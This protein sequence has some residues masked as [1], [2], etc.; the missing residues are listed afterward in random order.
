M[1]SELAQQISRIRTQNLQ[2]AGPIRQGVPSLFLSPK[3]AAGIDIDQTYDAALNGLITLSQYDSR[4]SAFR[5]GILHPSSMSLQREL[6]TAAENQ[7]LDRDISSL[8]NYLS[9]YAGEPAAH[10][11]IEYLIRRY[12]VHELNVDALIRCLIAAHDSKVSYPVNML[13]FDPPRSYTPLPPSHPFL[14]P[15]RLVGIR[16]SSTTVYNQRHRVGL[17]GRREAVGF[18]PPQT[19][20]SAAVHE[21]CHSADSTQCSRP[22][23]TK[24][25][26]RRRPR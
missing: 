11:I 5:D 10:T 14:L 16:S 18:T 22:K 25:G 2:S 21:R 7:A 26:V 12:R 20:D 6:K 15:Y 9:L 23:R 4:L 1:A 3:E 13:S 24:F 17:S 8:L 19:G